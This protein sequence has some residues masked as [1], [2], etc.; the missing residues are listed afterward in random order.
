MFPLN[1]LF[2]HYIKGTGEVLKAVFNFTAF[3]FHLFSVNLLLQTLFSPWRRIEIRSDKKGFS[4]SEFFHDFSFNLISRIIGLT[5]RLLLI[6]W[7]LVLALT[8][9]LL[10]F[11]FLFF[12]PFLSPLTLFIFFWWKS[13]EIKDPEKV[14]DDKLIKLLRKGAKKF[15]FKRLGI[16]KIS[17]LKDFK[18]E[19][20]REVLHWY[21]ILRKK[22]LKK[23]K[24]WSRENL[25]HLPSLGS[26]LAFGY[27]PNLD[28]YSQDLSFPPPF[29]HQLVGREREIKQIEAVLLRSSQNNVLLVGE[30]GVGKQ[31]I[32]LGFAK[33]IK[34][35]KTNPGLFY[36]R[37]LL[38][39]M[40]LI[41]G[42]AGLSAQAKATFNLLLQEA[43]QAGNVILVIN[44]IERYLSNEIGID[45]TEVI[46][47][48]VRY[49]KIQL[50]ATT[51]PE[52]YEKYIFSNEEFVK[53]FEK[54]EVEPPD[55]KEALK[56]LQSIA[57]DFEKNKKVI[58]SYQ[59]LKEIIEQS[60]KLI[61][62]IPFPEKAID[63]LDQLIVQAEENKISFIDV[64]EV[65]LLI[66]EKVKIP[67]G[68]ISQQEKTKLLNLEKI[69]S[70]R[71]VNQRKAI[72]VLVKAMQ[73]VR[74]GVGESNKPIG[75]FLFLGPTGVGKTETAK[76]LAFAYFGSEKEMIR[77]DLTQDFDWQLLVRAVREKPYGVL[78]LDEFEKASQE[79]MNLFLPVFDEG[80]LKD[81]EGKE[82]SFKNL[83]IICTSN[84][85][86]EF[87]RERVNKG[88]TLTNVIEEVMKKGFFT[89]ELIN[90]FDAVVIF[91]PLTE[92]EI[93]EI[94]RH[95]LEK[96]IKNMAEKDVILTIDSL[97]YDYL[98]KTGY[99]PEF[100]ARPLKR[101][102]SDKIESLLAEKILKEE[103]KKGDKIK[104]TLD[105]SRQ[106]FTMEKSE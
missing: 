26:E 83:I 7:S 13:G 18:T 15:V 60:E 8:L 68:S 65:D 47:R 66:S 64:K 98:V 17:E 40:S 45:L 103:I 92:E 28:N 29:A 32:L 105:S 57:L 25:F 31:A 59:A 81:K 21:Y 1:F 20:L 63:L 75:A 23:L 42:Q 71:L 95:Q 76:A 53:Y 99:Q 72:E 61:T 35:K 3:S 38:L 19:D 84:A 55:K 80:Y 51:T 10:S 49:S 106:S 24:F 88:L 14:A 30:P 70:Q 100:G 101:L 96:V 16:K 48:L 41:I 62:H 89:P 44:H 78:L 73:R 36:K 43:Q 69:L 52:F 56:I 4:I 93:K 9:F 34:E 54:I 77:F 22:K 39:D 74:M 102:I 6:F 90:R 11:I 79:T 82:V 67:V 2:W 94:C 104:I 33:A 27:T 58:A 12:W 91:Q 86:A 37:V 97:V 50:I 46:S 87:I 85:G 5:V